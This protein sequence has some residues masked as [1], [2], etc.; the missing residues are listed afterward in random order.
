MKGGAI[1]FTRQVQRGTLVARTGRRLRPTAPFFPVDELGF[2]AWHDG[3]I[4]A[5]AWI[6]FGSLLFVKGFVE[7]EI[8]TNAVLP[9]AFFGL[10]VIGE[11]VGDPAVDL[12]QGQ[13]PL[14]RAQDGHGNEMGIAALRLFAIILQR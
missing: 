5:L 6:V 10:A 4:I 8:V 14:G 13:F 7:T 11:G 12:G 3:P 1:G 2:M 9:A